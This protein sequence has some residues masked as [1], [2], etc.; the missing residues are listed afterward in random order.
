MGRHTR[1]HPAQK[2]A[3]DDHVGVGAAYAD[4]TLGGDAAGAHIAHAATTARQ[5]KGAVGFL[6]VE[7]IEAGVASQ[8][9]QVLEHGTGGWIAGFGDDV[10]LGWEGGAVDAQNTGI[11]A[12]GM[13]VVVMVLS[14]ALEI[15]S[16]V[17]SGIKD[18]AMFARTGRPAVFPA[19]FSLVSAG[20]SPRAWIS[21][22]LRLTR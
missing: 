9:R 3:G 16:V 11:V 6:R 18:K 21:P 19:R 8:G 4:R 7:P 15:D 1:G 5:A 10:G 13:L 2:V 22:R 20:N 14:H 12:M 17:H